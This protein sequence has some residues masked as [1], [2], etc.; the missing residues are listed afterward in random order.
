MWKSLPKLIL[1]SASPRRTALLQQ[2]GIPHIVLAPDFFE[3]RNPNEEAA[4]YTLRNA[5]GKAEAVF[6]ATSEQ[7]LRLI[8]AADTIVVFQGEVLE[9][10]LDRDD[11]RR[12][13]SQ[14]SG[15]QHEVISALHLILADQNVTAV[16]SDTVRTR[17]QFR[18]L[19]ADEIEAY[20]DLGEPMDKAGSYGAQGVGAAFVEAVHGSY[21]NV[22]GLPL[23]ELVGLLEGT[24][25]FKMF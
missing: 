13:L 17:V 12:M 16:A 15:C 20:I 22:V 24:L 21:S 9:K 3:Q 1:A 6:Q 19:R 23:A 5:K 8:L 25:N 2:I 10:P 11:A 18:T 7:G 4:A 14:L